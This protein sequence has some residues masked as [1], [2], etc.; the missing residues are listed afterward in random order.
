VQF[1]AVWFILEFALGM[2]AR[3]KYHFLKMP[4]A[5]DI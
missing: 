4:D 2:R 5:K 1:L 3:Q